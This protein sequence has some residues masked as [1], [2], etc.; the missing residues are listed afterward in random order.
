MSKILLLSHQRAGTA[1]YCNAF[2][3]FHSMVNPKFI[4]CISEVYTD[5]YIKR[6]K[7]IKNF[8]LNENKIKNKNSAELTKTFLYTFKLKNFIIKYFPLAIEQFCSKELTLDFI[9]NLCLNGGVNIYFLYR[10][11]IL[12][13]IISLLISNYTNIWH[14]DSIRKIQINYN[15][16]KFSKDFLKTNIYYGLKEIELCHSYYLILKTENILS[17]IITYEDNILKKNFEFANSLPP[18]Y[19]KLNSD[20]NKEIVLRNNPLIISYMK[21]YLSVININCSDNFIIQL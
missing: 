21:R 3:N 20:E 4:P 9:H 8:N 13:S 17:N 14:I 6:K 12:D 11:N 15:D 18:Y 16:I 5:E 10:K 2:N 1:I 7:F 19:E